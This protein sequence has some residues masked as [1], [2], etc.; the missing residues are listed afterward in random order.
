MAVAATAVLAILLTATPGSALAATALGS[1]T[2][3]VTTG[4]RESYAVSM[5]TSYWSVVAT[6]GYQGGQ[7]DIALSGPTGTT[8]G[9]SAEGFG[10]VDW[11]AVDNNS[12]RHPLGAYTADVTSTTDGG[13][14]TTH[15]TQFVGGDKVLAA[16]QPESVV[17]MANGPWLVDVR[18]INLQAGR[19]VTF[20]VRG[21]DSID[22][23]TVL[24]STPDPT[25]W[26]RTRGAA[27]LSVEMPKADTDQQTYSFTYTA[28]ASGWYGVVF[29]SRGWSRWVGQSS[30]G[31]GHVSV[32]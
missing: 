8:V 18:D 17:G 14:P 3:V 31:V 27:A 16:S 26:T 32:S 22:S 20:T 4:V 15:L 11:V 19:T 9:R 6:V 25:T 28:P 2:A 7:S 12:G 24:Q 13:R 10:T 5:A 21:L 29:E 23:V 30:A 1:G